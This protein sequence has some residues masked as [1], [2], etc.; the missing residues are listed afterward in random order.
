MCYK[1]NQKYFSVV[2]EYVLFYL[3]ILAFSKLTTFLVKYRYLLKKL[4]WLWSPGA[5]AEIANR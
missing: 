2:V 4:F 3:F 5:G 1:S